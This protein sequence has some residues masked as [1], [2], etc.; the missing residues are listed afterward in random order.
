MTTLDIFFLFMITTSLTLTGFV[1]RQRKNNRMLGELVAQ[2][3]V[4]S[5]SGYSKLDVGVKNKEYVSKCPAC[6]EWISLEAKVCKSCQRNVL[7]HNLGIRES[8]KQIDDEIK[9]S[10]LE[11]KAYN[12]DRRT[13]LLKNP[14]FRVSLAL[15]IAFS[16][17][18]SAAF[19]QSSIRYR[20]ATAMPVSASSLI[21]SWDSIIVECGFPNGPSTPKAKLYDSRLVVLDIS[22]TSNLGAFDW[23]SPL[24]KKVQ[25]FSKKALATNV[26][27]KL[28][29]DGSV[30][31]DLPNTYAIQGLNDKS[32]IGFYWDSDSLKS[33]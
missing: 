6:A 30:D 29:S 9:Q 18:I 26:S 4:D 7:E 25:C 15:V 33:E 8:M 1:I 14:I 22:L 2:N 31:I 27:K 24:G 13:A 5:R 21:K 11:L 19:I 10:E 17:F 28:N 3:K 32:D 20:K 23:S 16:L 12:R